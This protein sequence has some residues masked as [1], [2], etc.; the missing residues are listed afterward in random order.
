M[1]GRHEWNRMPQLVDVACPECGGAALFEFAEVLGIHRRDGFPDSRESSRFEDWILDHGPQR[2]WHGAFY[3]S[4]LHGPPEAALRK[5][6]AGYGPSNWKHSHDLNRSHGTD[7]GQ[8]RFGGC[9]LRTGHRLEWPKDASSRVDHCSH[10]LWAFQRE[11]GGE[12]RSHIASRDRAREGY[13]WD[14]FL[15]HIPTTFLRAKARNAVVN[16][17]DWILS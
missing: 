15:R 1:T 13:Q 8:V 10:V 12:L 4:L 5:L 3:Y 7:A 16:R 9:G 2:R 14:S 11:S 6:P 17:L